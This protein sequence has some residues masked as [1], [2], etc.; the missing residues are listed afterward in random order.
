MVASARAMSNVSRKAANPP[1]RGPH[2]TA[3]SLV[4]KSQDIS[5]QVFLLI[6]PLASVVSFGVATILSVPR[7]Y[8]LSAIA[9]PGAILEKIDALSKNLNDQIQDASQSD[10]IPSAS[11]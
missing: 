11:C 9:S 2:I 8:P 5:L 7:N 4:A 6:G 1:L 3:S 10:Q